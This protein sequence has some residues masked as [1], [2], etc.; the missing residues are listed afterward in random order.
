MDITAFD[1]AQRFVGTD[2]VQGAA[3]NPQ[4]LAMLQLD[5][6][7]PKDD[8]VPWCSAFVNYIA[9]LLRL[10]RSK[11]LAARSWL[12][13]G[14]PIELKDATPG[15]DIVVLDRPPDKASGHVGFFAGFD[16][17]NVH[18]LGGNQKDSVSIATF[19]PGHVIGVR[20]LLAVLLMVAA[21]A[22][23]PAAAQDGVSLSTASIE[24]SAGDVAGWPITTAITKL[25]IGAADCNVEFDKKAGTDRWPSVAIPG[26]NGGTIQ[27]TLWLVRSV[28]GQVYT[29]GGIEFW[30]G[31][32]GGCGPAA[33]YIANWYYDSS[34][35]PLHDA[36]ELT[37]GETVG[38][39]VTAGDAR[40]KDVRTVTARSAVV[41]LP[42]PGG[43][44]GT[45]TF[46][47]QTP[48]PVVTPPPA[49]IVPPPTPPVIAP[50]PAPVLDL[51]SVVAQLAAI[52]EDLAAARAE[53]QV[54]Y[55]QVRSKWKDFATFVAKWGSVIA[56][57][58]YGGMK[59]GGK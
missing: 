33:D 56:G 53:N 15:F 19:G 29:G 34:W 52:R 12:Q 35:G 27:Y 9:W 8:A 41:A 17:I 7:W 54:F 6:K 39:F 20:R 14:R 5:G 31:R 48:P 16:G 55:D 44:G 24:R 1:L 11:S 43:A 25:E 32:K 50:P 10:P 30:D 38:F 13:V 49:V 18:V 26:W 2:E 45:F 42:W 51:S 57:S 36:G 23:A 4:V 59:L 21:A 3:S 28:G 22:V 37:P 40:A 47:P 46:G 58:I